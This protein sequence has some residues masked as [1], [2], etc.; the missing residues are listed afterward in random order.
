[1]NWDQSQYPP[2]WWIASD[3][4]WYPPELHPEFRPSD[5]PQASSWDPPAGPQLLPQDSI[6]P[7]IGSVNLSPISHQNIA[8]GLHQDYGSRPRQDIVSGLHQDYGNRPRQDIVSGLHQDY[9]NR[10]HQNTVVFHSSAEKSTSVF[11]EPGLS[12]LKKGWEQDLGRGVR[13]GLRTERKASTYLIWAIILA[14]WY[15]G[16]FYFAIRDPLNIYLLFVSAPGT[17]AFLAAR[18]YYRI[19]IRR[20]H[21]TQTGMGW[22]QETKSGLIQIKASIY[23]AIS[24][25]VL[26]FIGNGI[27]WG[28]QAFGLFG[29]NSSTNQIV[30]LIN[31][32]THQ[33]IRAGGGITTTTN[34]IQ[35]ERNLQ[36]EL[37]NA[38]L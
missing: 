23:I 13:K 32:L 16:Y 35:A 34:P 8:S 15:V 36:R 14:V 3:G 27:V 5:Q 21:Q 17:G 37:S 25:M 7:N 28:S 11:A 12:P 31:P 4:N 26:G 33:P 20:V 9:G 1:M 18:A 22:E 29:G 30:K 38:G 2:G 10:P 19:W 24:A 6:H